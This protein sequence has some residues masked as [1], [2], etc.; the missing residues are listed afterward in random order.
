L[1]TAKGKDLRSIGVSVGDIESDTETA[2]NIENSPEN[3][4]GLGP[5]NVAGPVG[6]AP[7]GQ[8]G[9][10][11]GAAGAPAAGGLATPGAIG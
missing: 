5:E 9:A 8:A 6:T 3:Q 11:A 10:A 2:D 7:A 4:E 1:D